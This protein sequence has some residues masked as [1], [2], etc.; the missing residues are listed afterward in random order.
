MAEARTFTGY[1]QDRAVARQ[2]PLS[3][4]ISRPALAGALDSSSCIH[5]I[6]GADEAA[7]YAAVLTLKLAVLAWVGTI[8]PA[9][10]F[11]LFAA[12]ALF[13]VVLSSF[14]NDTELID[15]LQPLTVV[16]SITVSLAIIRHDLAGYARG[17]AFSG[18]LMCAGYMAS[19]AAGAIE[20]VGDRY[21]F[22]AG[23]H[24]NLGGELI[25]T[26]L[27]MSAFALRPRTFLPLA[28]ASLYCTFMLQSRT[29]TIAIILSVACYLLLRAA[30]RFGQ[31]TTAWAAGGGFL[32]IG[33]LA[34]SLGEGPA[35]EGPLADFL[36]DSVFLVEDQYRGGAS[37]FSG[38]DQHWQDTLRVIADQPILGTGPGYAP[39]VGS[40]QPHNW[41]LYA[42]SQYGVPGWGLVGLF[43][44]ASVAAVRRDPRRLLVL[45]PLFVPWLLND[46]FLNFNAYPFV[47][48]V[49]VFAA[50]PAAGRG[51]RAR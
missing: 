20:A 4:W 25:S 38:R 24:P 10:R 11:V 49:V 45:V 32:L 15:A 26:T 29:A 21:K 22:F 30:R 1:G 16:V 50:F 5:L 17:M 48:Y 46:R 44:G 39:R 8:K 28:A 23:S 3:R 47:L 12:T 2:F 13:A 51:R 7:F 33:A 42:I 9:E 31:R 19:L 6:A 40:L 18:V 37:G 35:S 14:A 34:L 36:Y 27:V 43:L 41:V